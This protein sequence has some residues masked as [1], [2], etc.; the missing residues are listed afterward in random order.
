M[1]QLCQLETTSM[2]AVGASAAT[3]KGLI[4]LDK[5]FRD[6]A[7]SCNNSEADCVVGGRIAQLKYLKEQ[8]SSTGN[9]KSKMLE[10]P[11]A[12]HT[13]AMDPIL[14]ELT[15]FAQAFHI[16][17][18][19]IP[20][21]SNVFGRVVRAGERVF[22]PDYFALH[23][24][25][26]V[27][28]DEGV[29]DL[30]QTDIETIGSRWIELGPHPS[31]L[32][33]LSPRFGKASVELLPSLRKGVSPSA[34]IS[35]LLSHFYLST[36]GL[37]WR[38]I[39]DGKLS[40][41]LIDIPGMPYFPKEFRA[42]YQEASDDE[43]SQPVPD[44]DIPPHTFLSRIV[45]RPSTTNDHVSIYETDI[46]VLKDYIL[47]H[48]VCDYALCPA[49]VYHE[50]ALSA[51]KDYRTEKSDNLIWSLSNVNYSSP[52]LYIEEST[53]I[54][55]TSVHPM[56][57]SGSLYKFSISTYSERSNI[58]QQ[59][60]HCEGLVKARPR[61]LTAQKYNRLGLT[62]GRKKVQYKSQT[63][64]QEVFFTKAM[65]EKI[66]TRVVTYSALYQGMWSFSFGL[67]FV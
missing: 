35:K 4:R 7:I 2:L 16:A 39:Y 32:P 9:A 24:R 11:L 40:A 41:S 63:S 50:M 25:Q 53:V 14:P 36:T 48:I 18:P 29:Q 23:C 22:T 57:D 30:L 10:V 62:L 64:S 17:A 43:G 15:T 38:K 56:H 27:A 42:A 59:T 20:V 21:V 1:M 46:E 8:L 5:N 49:S 33:M 52:L 3:V 37:N 47:G 44:A 65:Y 66:F 19:K 28:F 55:R 54:V 26:T 31:L 60:V 58:E 34:T 61:S 51:V 67:S 6:L 13:E 12:Y 45:Q